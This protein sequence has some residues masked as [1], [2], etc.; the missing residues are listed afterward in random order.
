MVDDAPRRWCQNLA[1][2]AGRK[3]CHHVERSNTLKIFFQIYVGAGKRD[4][5]PI[6][7]RVAV[8]G[9][10]MTPSAV[11]HSGC[12]PGSIVIYGRW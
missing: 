5:V 10:R 7:K 3:P 9:P 6:D 11:V 12:V 1:T 4:Y 8:D 2:T